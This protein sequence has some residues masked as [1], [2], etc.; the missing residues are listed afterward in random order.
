MERIREQVLSE[1]NI[2]KW[3]TP[4]DKWKADYGQNIW[5][6]KVVKAAI[7]MGDTAEFLIDCVV[8]GIL[9]LLKD[10]LACRYDTW[11]EFKKDI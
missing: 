3:I 7:T 11:E 9:N 5:A 2:G 4:L 8:D 6:N 1:E 10:H